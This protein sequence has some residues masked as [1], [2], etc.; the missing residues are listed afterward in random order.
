MK[1]QIARQ[2]QA[3]QSGVKKYNY[4]WKNTIFYTKFRY[5]FD[6]LANETIVTDTFAR[7][8]KQRFKNPQGSDL[9]GQYKT[10]PHPMTR[11]LCTFRGIDGVTKQAVTRIFNLA[12][13]FWG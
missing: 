9:I 7:A 10:H 2:A 13:Y 8:C 4:L 11:F 6:L 5:N 3:S 12:R 1:R